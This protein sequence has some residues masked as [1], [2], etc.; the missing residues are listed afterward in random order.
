MASSPEAAIA[1]NIAN[2]SNPMDEEILAA[3]VND[4]EGLNVSVKDGSFTNKY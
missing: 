2:N 4:A 3:D 1:L